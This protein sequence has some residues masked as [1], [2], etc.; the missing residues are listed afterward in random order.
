VWTVT[1]VATEFNY[2]VRRFLF[3]D[4]AVT[5]C[6]REI[7]VA[8]LALTRVMTRSKV[9]HSQS[10]TRFPHMIMFPVPG[11]LLGMNHVVR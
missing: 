10:E 6:D 5:G 1:K 2:A 3:R 9:P 11:I 8:H 4:R 7:L